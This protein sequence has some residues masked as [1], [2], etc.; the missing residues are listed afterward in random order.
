MHV[1]VFAGTRPEGV[2]M[3]PVVRVLRETDGLRCSLVSTG[4]HREMLQRTLADFGLKPDI[5]LAV[6]QPDQTLA[7]LSSRLFARVD[8]VLASLN[9]DW[10]LVQGDTTTVMVAA[11]CAFYRGIRI[12]HVEAGLRSHDMLAPFPEELNRRVAG[13]VT[14]LHFAPT[15]ASA[16]NLMAERVSAEQIV[17]TGNTGIDALLQTAAVVRANP[18]RLPLDIQAF[19]EKHDRYVLI[20]GHRRE[21]FGQGFQSICQAISELSDTHSSVGFLYPVH[22]NPRV[23]GP[24]FSIVRDRANVLLTDP[25]EYRSFVY[26]MDRSH[27]L[28]SDSG[29]VQE[30]APSLGKPVLVMRDVTERPEGIE[31]GC[32]ELVGS[33]AERIFNRV[34][35][36]LTDEGL[37][38]AMARAQNPYGDGL[39]SQRIV[40]ALIQQLGM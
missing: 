5:D 31:A 23:R 7:S 33:S 40:Q 1:V 24:V 26:L 25:Q 37:Y 29:G 34:T 21:N 30:E 17:V 3:A 14:K 28:L 8:E 36:L 19:L 4:Q 22:L 16:A 9:P 32:A 2:K 6:M 10:V 12:G 11:L 20:T 27:L 13:L 18:P 35:A 39:S 15:K 38:Q